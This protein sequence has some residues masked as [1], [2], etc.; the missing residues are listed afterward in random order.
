ML[1]QI[2]KCHVINGGFWLGRVQAPVPF[3]T[4][5]ACHFGGAVATEGGGLILELN[6]LD[7]KCYLPA[8]K[9]DNIILAIKWDNIILASYW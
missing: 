7:S 9:W 4:R 5:G 8:I 2:L 3:C 1:I 6:C